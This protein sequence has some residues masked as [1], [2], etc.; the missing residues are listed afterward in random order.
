VK[1][2]IDLMFYFVK[3]KFKLPFLS[4]KTNHVFANQE[5]EPAEAGHQ[6]RGSERFVAQ[7]V[8]A[9]GWHLYE[10][11]CCAQSW[12][13]ATRYVRCGRRSHTKADGF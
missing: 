1:L 5:E 13:Y 7:Q 8:T 9:A 12:R 11:L 3:L 6:R 2:N 4:Q 10:C